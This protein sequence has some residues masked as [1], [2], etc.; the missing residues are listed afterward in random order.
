MKTM[1]TF[2]LERAIRRKYIFANS[3]L[4]ESIEAC[5]KCGG[6]VNDSREGECSWY[7]A[8]DKLEKILRR[9]EDED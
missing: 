1:E 4:R 8:K 2:L 6:C 3:L 9:L 5:N 7:N